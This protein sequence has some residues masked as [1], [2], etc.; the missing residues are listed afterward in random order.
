[1]FIFILLSLVIVAITKLTLEPNS[2]ITG[3]FVA[4][5][6][7]NTTSFGLVLLVMLVYSAQASTFSLIIAE[8]FK[9]RKNWSRVILSFYDAQTFM[10]ITAFNAKMVTL[11]FWVISSV[12]LY[13]FL[14]LQHRQQ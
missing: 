12:N 14:Q 2:P 7:L 6:I 4:K 9:T 3:Y 11:L 1:M 5:S 10:F 8:Y 13:D